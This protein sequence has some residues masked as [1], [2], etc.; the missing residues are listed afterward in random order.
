MPPL[1]PVPAVP[2]PDL[3]PPVFNPSARGRLGCLAGLCLE[4]LLGQG[5]MGEVFYAVDPRSKQAFAL[6]VVSSTARLGSRAAQSLAVEAGIQAR[7]VH[8]NLVR[9]F[10]FASDR[11]RH[12]LVLEY[13]P[14]PALD[15]WFA[16]LGRPLPLHQALSILAEVL[17]GLAVVHGAGYVH[18]DLKP[19]NVLL[20]LQAGRPVGAKLTDFGIAT[21][22]RDEL[23]GDGIAGT[24]A[25]MA[26]EQVHGRCPISGRS[27]LYAAGA[28][29]FELLTGRPPLEPGPETQEGFLHR[30]V[31]EP[32]PDPREFAPDLPGPIAEA[33]NRCLRKDPD[34]RPRSAEELASMLATAL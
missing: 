16:R 6:K 14:G 26:P 29:L 9:V 13:V 32:P 34:L 28:M 7:L 12:G 5:A 22:L 11:G 10:R 31:T 24:P 19:G 18:R 21:R 2:V 27:D 30:V 3:F 17:D 15:A 8:P 20:P 33:I 23:A 1:A 4:L 25:Y